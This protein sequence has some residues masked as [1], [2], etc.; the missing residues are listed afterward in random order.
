METRQRLLDVD[1]LHEVVD[2]PV[3]RYVIELTPLIIVPITPDPGIFDA[4]RI[5][6]IIAVE[7][8]PGIPAHDDDQ[9]EEE[10]HRNEGGEELPPRVIDH[11]V[12]VDPT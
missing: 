11:P 7:G 6:Q 12:E 3:T 2:H 1:V 5:L 10:V 8:H 9:C 4:S